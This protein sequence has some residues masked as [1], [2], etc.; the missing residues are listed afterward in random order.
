MADSLDMLADAS[1]Y[2]VALCAVGRSAGIERN[3]AMASGLD[4]IALGGGVLIDVGRRYL[5]DS[6]P[7]SALMVGIGAAAFIANVACLMLIAKSGGRGSHARLVD[8]PS[9]RRYR[10]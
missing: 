6:E 3:A 5:Y 7:S 4:Q 1:V 10:Q 8:F 2:G 9:Q